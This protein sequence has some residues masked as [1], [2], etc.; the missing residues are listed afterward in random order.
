MTIPNSTIIR[1]ELLKFLK[2]SGSI[3]M[4]QVVKELSKIFDLNEDDISK[5]KKSGNGT[6]F[7]SRVNWAKYH[8]KK[9]GLVSSPKK[10]YV[11]IT[12]LGTELLKKNNLKIDTKFLKSYHI[13]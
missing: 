9:V 5:M 2:D 3:R 13:M 11:K 12:N 10:G 1:L 6:L 4:K 8:L 7:D